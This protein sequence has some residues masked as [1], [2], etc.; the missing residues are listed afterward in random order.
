MR[1]GVPGKSRLRISPPLLLVA[2]TSLLFSCSGPTHKTVAPLATDLVEIAI[3]DPTIHLDMRYATSD[4]FT[5]RAV[6]PEPRAFLRRPVAEAL[7]SVH[8]WLKERGYGIVIFDAYRPLSVTKIFWEITPPDKRMFVAD[9]AVGSMHNRATA[10]DVG[11]Y[12]LKTGL[13]VEM[14]S[15]YD[16]FSERSFVVYAGGTPEQRRAR[17]LLRLGMERDGHFFVL[18]EEWWHFNHKDWHDYPILDV[19]FPDI[20][21]LGKN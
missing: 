4:N 13:E 2:W 17:D 15:R 21:P 9:P 11:L 18:P 3:L 6:Y 20:K 10:V 12:D 14:P 5:G 8:R 1:A 7:L 16:D 19:A